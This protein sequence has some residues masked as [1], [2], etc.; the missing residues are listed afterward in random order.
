MPISLIF[1]EQTFDDWSGIDIDEMTFHT[2]D[3]ID[4]SITYWRNVRSEG[5]DYYG[6]ENEIV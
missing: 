3:D 6:S 1:Q 4:D 2:G 5:D